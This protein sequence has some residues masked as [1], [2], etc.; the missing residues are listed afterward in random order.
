M[1]GFFKRH[2]TLFR[3]D[4]TSI[5]KELLLW[6]KAVINIPTDLCSLS[7]SPITENIIT[8]RLFNAVTKIIKTQFVQ[9]REM[10]CEVQIYFL[11]QVEKCR[12]NR[13]LVGDHVIGSTCIAAS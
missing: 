12:K 13:L 3:K 4:R 7:L 6:E 9:K 10:S 11:K 5:I 8:C 1:L 2:E